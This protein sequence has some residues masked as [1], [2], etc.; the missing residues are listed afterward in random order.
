MS[1]DVDIEKCTDTS[2]EMSIG[3]ASRHVH[4]KKGTS[5]TYNRYVRY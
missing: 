5:S 3:I 2:M 4:G 1:I